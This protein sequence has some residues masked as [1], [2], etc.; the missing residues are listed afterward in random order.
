M[1]R[2]QHILFCAAPAPEH[3]KRIRPECLRMVAPNPRPGHHPP[4]HRHGPKD[5]CYFRYQVTPEWYQI[6][7]ESPKP[8]LF[9]LFRAI[10]NQTIRSGAF[11]LP[12]EDLM[13]ITH[14]QSPQQF[15]CYVVNSAW[16][17]RINTQSDPESE[18]HP[19]RQFSLWASGHHT[20]DNAKQNKTRIVT[21]ANRPSSTACPTRSV[22]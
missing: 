2:V 3:G 17:D 15:Q 21:A 6:D 11:K 16:R 14:H 18:A 19:A 20:A 4:H 12:A 9:N 8:N 13:Q 1:R 22:R 7:C 10:R 5:I